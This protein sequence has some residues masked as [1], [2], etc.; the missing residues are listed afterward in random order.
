M[1]ITAMESSK[2]K[3]ILALRIA[4][5]VHSLFLSVRSSLGNVTRIDLAVVISR[6]KQG[7]L[8]TANTRVGGFAFP[9]YI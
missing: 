3:F 8:I 9:D 6:Q 4:Q 2:A 5:C 7:G 1:T